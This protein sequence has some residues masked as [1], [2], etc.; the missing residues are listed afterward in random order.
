ML[1]IFMIKVLCAVGGCESGKDVM[2]ELEQLRESAQENFEDI[3]NN[4]TDYEETLKIERIAD[5]NLPIKQQEEII[6]QGYPEFTNID[7]NK[8]FNEILESLRNYANTTRE[9]YNDVDEYYEMQVD[10]LNKIYVVQ[11]LF[12]VKKKIHLKHMSLYLR[13][14]NYDMQLNNQQNRQDGSEQ[15]VYNCFVSETVACNSVSG[16]KEITDAI[17]NKNSELIKMT[18][19]FRKLEE[20][21]LRLLDIKKGFLDAFYNKLYENA[22]YEIEITG[23]AIPT[24]EHIQQ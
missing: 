10:S 11:H 17:F 21:I 20:T 7:F 9:P 1:L 12:F 16:I 6:K 4:V 19:M 3:K 8:D 15:C 23:A 14:V 24:D 18:K 2:N 13:A 5:T 22:I